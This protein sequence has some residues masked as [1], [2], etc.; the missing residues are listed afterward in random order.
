MGQVMIDIDRLKDAM[1]RAGLSQAALARNV[2]VSPAAIQQIVNGS[3][4][5]PRVLSEIAECLKVSPD[6]LEGK[7]DNPTRHFVSSS[8]PD[9]DDMMTVLYLTIGKNPLYD[10]SS[11]TNVAGI[12][13]SRSWLRYAMGVEP[14]F[15]ILMGRIH[16]TQMIPTIMP[17]DDVLLFPKDLFDQDP[18]SIWLCQFHGQT[19]M[20]RIKQISETRVS[21]V[22][23]NSQYPAFECDMEELK[24]IGKILWNGRRL[25]GA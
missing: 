23:D 22:A 21:V 5:R 10:T 19:I 9:D 18:D 8:D 3:T 17:G 7:T 12:K 6:W 16:Q 13:F 20:R 24:F 2:G 14:Q 4:K 15:G 11:E 1:Q 25:T